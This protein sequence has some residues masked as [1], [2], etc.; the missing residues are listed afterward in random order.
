MRWLPVH[1]VAAKLIGAACCGVVVLLATVVGGT[2]AAARAG[3]VQWSAYGGSNAVVRP[4]ELEVAGVIGIAWKDVSWATW[5]DS[6]ADGTGT[7]DWRAPT[8]DGYEYRDY[9]VHVT[10]TRIRPC[11]D[12]RLY[13]RLH[14]TFD[15][16]RPG[17]AG[18]DRVRRY[19]CRIVLGRDA[20]DLNPPPRWYGLGVSK[21]R[22]ASDGNAAALWNLRWRG[23]GG[24][25]AHASGRYALRP[26]GSATHP[27]RRYAPVTVRV[28]AFDSGECDSGYAYRKMRIVGPHFGHGRTFDVCR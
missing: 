1:V 14:T 24:R 26:P 11:G 23:W 19:D 8:P 4:T 10:L 17:Y 9:P 20:S 27:G 7:F 5:G 3:E 16:A 12:L 15:A 2:P 6:T 21:P 18:D 28:T 25:R 22:Q 13:T